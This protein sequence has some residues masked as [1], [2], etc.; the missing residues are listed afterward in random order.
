MKIFNIRSL[1][2]ILFLHNMPNYN[3]LK[4]K[5]QSR[6]TIINVKDAPSDNEWK[7]FFS[8]SFLWKKKLWSNLKKQGIDF[9][10]W[11]WS[12]RLAWI[13]SCTNKKNKFCAKIR[14]LGIN[15]KALVIR[16]ATA[17]ALGQTYRNTKNK[18]VINT[19]TKL[20]HAPKNKKTLFIHAR[21]LEA[22]SSIGGKYA[23]KMGKKLSYSNKDLKSMWKKLE[24]NQKGNMNQRQQRRS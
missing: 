9:D 19:L 4:G 22:I 10:D 7:L 21:I 1:I 18:N 12:W 17:V 15:D 5:A 14:R 16:S 3:E 6:V 2:V 24:E 13:R 20:F 8:R 23:N 11:N